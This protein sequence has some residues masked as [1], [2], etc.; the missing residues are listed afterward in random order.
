MHD[1]MRRFCLLGLWANAVTDASTA[2]IKIIGGSIMGM[3]IIKPGTITRGDAV[4]NIIE[5]VATEEAAFAHIL[6]AES[7]KIMAIVNNSAATPEQ[8]LAVNASVKNAISAIS[9]LEMQLQAK[10]DL[11]NH[12]VC[13]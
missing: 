8:L 5:S 7:E 4:G 6:N 13:E 12:T 10:L 9:R 11:F 3:P 2:R 1:K